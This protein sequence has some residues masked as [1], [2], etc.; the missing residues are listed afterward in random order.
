MPATRKVFAAFSEAPFGA[1]SSPLGMSAGRRIL[2]RPQ[3]AVQ[4]QCSTA[5]P[6]P[7]FDATAPATANISTL[8]AMVS[9]RTGS[10]AR[11]FLL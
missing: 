5:W 9:D 11:P 7:D 1:R 6:L 4:R 10:L 8:S 3:A 2:L